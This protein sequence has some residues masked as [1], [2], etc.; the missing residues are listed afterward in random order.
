MLFPVVVMPSSD[1]LGHIVVT[2]GNRTVVNEYYY[3]LYVCMSAELVR[4]RTPTRVPFL[5]TLGSLCHRAGMLL[6]VSGAKPQSPPVGGT[7]GSG[8]RARRQPRHLAGGL[9]LHLPPCRA[10]V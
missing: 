10:S 2:P 6:G 8:T 4:H 7:P 9:V 1:L 5:M 3:S